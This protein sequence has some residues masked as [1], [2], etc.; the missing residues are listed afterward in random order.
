MPTL[1][2]LDSS[3]RATSASRRLTAAFAARWRLKHPEGRIIHRNTTLDQ[4]PY[5]DAATVEAIAV[6][7]AQLTGAQKLALAFSDTLVD[8]LIAADTVA[9]G[10][11]MWNLTIPA[12]LKAWIDL[13]VREGRTFAFTKC[14]ARP[15]L[16][17]G[18]RVYVLA[19]RGGSY[20]RFTPMRSYDMQEPYLRKILGIIGLKRIEFI[21]ADHQSSSPQRAAA[22]LTRAERAVAQLIL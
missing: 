12:S 3:P 5:L 9:I 13:I 16:P 6:P 8:E 14:G 7:A 1:L 20:P 21:Y 11:P 15:L 19:A 22:G 4:M 18:K 2:H 10:A 17:K